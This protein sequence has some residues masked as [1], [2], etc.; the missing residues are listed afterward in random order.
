MG[1]NDHLNMEL[2]EAIRE[3][4]MRNELD[5]KSKEYG[6]AMQVAHQGLESLSEKQR[7]VYRRV[8]VLLKQQ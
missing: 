1:H 5:E 8:E 3:L 2:Y 4:V 6:I 7:A